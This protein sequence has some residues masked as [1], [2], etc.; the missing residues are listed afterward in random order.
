MP[1]PERIWRVKSFEKVH[2]TSQYPIVNTS[3]LA[4]LLAWVC[5]YRNCTYPIQPIRKILWLE[6]SCAIVED[7]VS[8]LDSSA[9]LA[10]LQGERARTSYSMDQILDASG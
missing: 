1:S 9:L 8:V 5:C 3:K 7:G 10:F 6:T 2:F 4:L